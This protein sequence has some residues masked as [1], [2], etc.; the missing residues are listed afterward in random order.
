MGKILHINIRGH[1]SKLPLSGTSGNKIT[2]S[3]RY[4]P[5]D[6]PEWFHGR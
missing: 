6:R 1:E 4:L 5:V 3:L 2:A